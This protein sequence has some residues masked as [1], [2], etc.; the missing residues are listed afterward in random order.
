[1]TYNPKDKNPSGVV[2]F[3]NNGS[4]QVFESVTGFVYDTGNTRLGI[5]TSSPKYTLD[6]SG[7]GSFDTIIFADGTKIDTSGVGGGGGTPGGS[8]TQVQ[9]NDSSSFGGD[10]DLTWNK[11]SNQLTINGRLNY[12]SS[13]S[14]ISN[15]GT[16]SSFTFDLDTSNVF[17]GTLNGSTTLATSNGD[18]GQ[19]FL[20]RLKQG[21]GGSK[22]VS[23]WFGGR[24]SWPGGSAPTL[25]STAGHVDLFGFLVTHGTAPT[26]YYDGF[27]IATGIQ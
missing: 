12:D 18:V 26:L 4:D 16:A 19:R 20:I 15:K 27:T 11:T 9:F 25:S 8:N 7:T 17:S 24:V 21:S 2:L 13:Y 14:T 1:M 3:G 22:T 23:S 6:V 5:S 10:A